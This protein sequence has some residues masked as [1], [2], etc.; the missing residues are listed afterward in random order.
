[1]NADLPI[2]FAALLAKSPNPYV[3][4]DRDLTIVWMNDAYL[5]AT[6][7]R[8]EDILG[9][10]MFQ[11]F[12]SDPASE[13]HRSLESSFSRVLRTGEVDELALIRYDIANPSGEMDTRFW[14][15]THT[16]VHDDAG[17]VRYILQHTVDVTE[18]HG[19]RRLRD[20]AGV[21]ERAGAIQAR[22]LDLAE[23]RD[24]FRAYFEQAPGFVAVLAGSRHVFLM[25]NAAY[26]RLVGGREIIGKSVLDALPEVAD[27]GFVGI[28]DKVRAERKTY[29][30][31]RAEVLL[32]T[33]GS[34]ELS[35]RFLNFAYQPIMGNGQVEAILVQGH[36]VTEE[37]AAEEAQKLLINEL[38]HR[39]KNT[40]AIV[41][42]LAAQSFRKLENGN[43][44]LHA[45]DARLKALAAAHSLLTERNWEPAQL[46]DTVRSAVEATVG[47]DI[48]RFTL[49][50]PDMTLTPQTGVSLAMVLHEL[51][52]NA[53]KYGALSVDDGQV[54]VDW[55]TEAEQDACVLTIDWRESGGPRVAQPTRRGFGTRLIERGL[56]AEGENK[57]TLDFH[58]DGLQCHFV[59]RIEGR[60]R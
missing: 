43:E 36:D 32:R 55:T 46:A 28:L 39:V 22:N 21:F 7:R 27:Q 41:Q 26:H 53:I 14:S 51:S 24:R 20:E 13:S 59:M 45:F 8:R 15:A 40:L 18:L 2:D 60:S 5:A 3:L 30:G 33:E 48:S 35:S 42:G 58:P 31:E 19:L 17:T 23:E 1:M 34:E 6:G 37:V 56:S 38:N 16:P 50:G 54:T 49:S 44:A 12:P 4:I 9:Q 10:G 57:V 11:A 52:T 47:T 25:A 29:L